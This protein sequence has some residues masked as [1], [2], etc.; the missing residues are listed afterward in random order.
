M[1]SPRITFINLVDL[2]VSYD[3]VVVPAVEGDPFLEADGG[4]DRICSV[5]KD[6]TLS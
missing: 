2:L 1:Y 3:Y 4:Q 6:P 5:Y